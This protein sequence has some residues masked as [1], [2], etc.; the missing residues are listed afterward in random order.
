MSTIAPHV[1]S[2]ALADIVVPDGGRELHQDEVT[3]IAA[4]MVQLGTSNRRQGE[5]LD[6]R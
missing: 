1:R 5:K 3:N 6:G 4:S 2:C